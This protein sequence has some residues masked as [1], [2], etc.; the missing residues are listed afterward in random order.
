MTD[1]LFEIGTEEIP[2]SYITPALNQME[3]L[4]TEY[5]KKHRLEMQSL[6]CTGTPRRLTMFVKGLPQKQESVTEE[7]QGPA[8]SIAFDKAGNPT[9]AGLGF[10][11]S[12]GVDIHNLQTKKTA[13]GEYCFAIKKVEG[14][15]T[16][17]ILPEIL[18]EIL[19]NI[20]F[21]KS[22][23]WKGNNLFFA[24]PIRSLLALFG[25]KVVPMEIN[26]IKA[27]RFVSGHPFLSGKRIEVS[28]ADWDLYKRLLK[29]EKVVVDMTERREALRTKITQ[30]MVPYGT[31]IDDEELLDEVTNL[32]EYPNA[33][34]CNFDKEF[35]D[36][37]ANVIETAMKE[38][39][40]YFPIK[41]KDGKLFNK[42]IAA[43]N[44]D[45][46]NADTAVQGNERVLR[47]RLSD[48]RFFWK[49]DRKVPLGKR[50]EDLKN[51]AF[52]E[53]LGNYR[54]RT[55]RIIKLSEYISHRLIA[56]NQLPI[57][58]DALVKR[59]A[60]LCKA[61]L[62]TQMVGEFPSLQGIMGREY[63]EWDGEEPSVALAI[64]EHYMPRFATDNIPKSKVGAIVGLADKFDTISSCFTLELTPTG[65]QDPYS[66]RRHAYGII[67]IIEEHGFALEFREV[68]SKSLS[69]L[70][71]F[72]QRE[73]HY[74]PEILNKLI[75]DI[76]EFFR[77]RLFH[78]NVERGH[79]YDLVNAVLNADVGFDDIYDFFQRL[80]ALSNVS[81]E[82]WWPDLVT[83]VER[84]FN[85]GKKANSSGS[86]NERL[87]T[88]AEE[89]KLLEIFKG[90][91]TA[92][93]K[94]VDEKKYEEASHTYYEVF[95]KPVHIFFDRVFVNV[96]D[97]AVRNNRLL[98]IKSINELYSGKIADLSQMDMSGE[99]S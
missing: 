1:L 86:V 16:L 60:L 47:A 48:A 91:E 55:D 75:P 10:A 32:V 5:A 37:P 45:E 88:E 96:E 61:D 19:K 78:I 4:F 83:V 73:S 53:K 74:Y 67:R 29:L 93:R 14:Q 63:A 20:S 22:M 44:R 80:K 98:L 65:S 69:L 84:T 41:K 57:E 38:H 95:A 92:I 17:H 49:E 87:F 94:Q 81:K 40:R 23:K 28:Q 51:L 59:A 82:E 62:L 76:K 56:F 58:A 39:Q 30:L 33:I 18:T 7:I 70:P 34:E 31:T 79:R 99:K 89:H 25:D 77:D 36:I 43:L 27:D 2:A 6:Y 90:N 15:E 46:N 21:P 52:L 97:E 13:K 72:P 64:A 12:Q 11:R 66:L 9:K 54:D 42:F 68:L 85:I 26:G 71:M 35:L 3:A 24:R 8:A 50:V